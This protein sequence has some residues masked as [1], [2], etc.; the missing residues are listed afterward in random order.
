MISDPALGEVVGADSLA[1]VAG[2]HLAAANS[3]LFPFSLFLQLIIKPGPENFQGFL[4]VFVLRLLILAG[5]Y[6]PGRQVRNPD[7]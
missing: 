1:A 3:S 5:Y 2:A 7:S 6:Q 4:L